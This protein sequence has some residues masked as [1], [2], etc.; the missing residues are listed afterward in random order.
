MIPQVRPS[1][2]TN[3]GFR[4]A[5]CGLASGAAQLKLAFCMLNNPT[6]KTLQPKERLARSLYGE[7][8]TE[9]PGTGTQVQIRAD[10]HRR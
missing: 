1:A 6:L 5:D 9:M 7:K 4:I 8:R 10:C 2:A 3:F